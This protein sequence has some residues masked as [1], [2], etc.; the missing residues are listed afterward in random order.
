M[1]IS[2]WFSDSYIEFEFN[3]RLCISVERRAERAPN[4]PLNAPTQKGE[5]PIERPEPGTGE[6]VHFVRSV[7][8][9]YAS[10]RCVLQ[11]RLV[12]LLASLMLFLRVSKTMILARKSC[13]VDAEE[14]SVS[15]GTISVGSDSKN[16]GRYR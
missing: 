5:K 9:D 8:R 10:H 13:S 14:S 16:D 3:L 6:R 4:L 15:Q 1:W 2:L 12:E 11:P 7:R